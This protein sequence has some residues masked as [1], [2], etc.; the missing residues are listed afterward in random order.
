MTT[1]YVRVRLRVEGVVQGV[2][3]RP[4]VHAIAVRH[5]LTGLVANDLGGVLIEAAGTAESLARFRQALE[6]EAPPL[7]VIERISAQSV[8]PVG[9]GE[10]TGD[11]FLIAAS[12]SGTSVIANVDSHGRSTSADV[13]DASIPP[14]IA[15]CADCLRELFDPTDRRFRHPFINC[16]N[17]GPRFTVVRSLPYDRVRTTMAAFAMCAA[18]E[19][20]YHDPSDRRF[21]AQPLC[22]PAC[23]PTLRLVD[24]ATGRAL[25]GDPVAEA[26]EMLRAGRVLAV[27]GLG[28]YHLAVDS[29][30]EPAVRLLRSRKRREEKPFAVMVPDTSTARRLCE[31]E[32]TGLGLLRSVR[33][34]IVLLPRRAGA[35]LAASVAPGC[36]DLGLMLPYTPLHHLLCAQLARPYVLTSGNLFDEP[37]AYD[38][39]DA[40]RRLAG[41]ADAFLTHDRPI[42]ARA[43]DSVVR[44]VTGGAHLVRR[45]RGHAPEPLALLSPAQRP[46]L[47]CG[48]QLKSTFCLARGRRAVVS[49]HVGDLKHPDALRSF[50]DGVAHHRRLFGIDPE[51]IAHDLHP[52]YLSTKYAH[53]LADTWGAELVGVQHHHAHIAS[54]LV[55]NG[56]RGPVIGVAFDGLGY[57]SDHTLWGGEFL[58]AD[59][60]GFRRAG[61]FTPV[62]LPG[63]EAAVREPWRMAVVY[64]DACGDGRGDGLAVR[65]RNADRWEEV[66]AVA[67][68]G[69]H[70]PPTSSVGRLFDA[71]AAL[72]DLRDAVS[73]EG[74]AA[75]ELERCADPSVTGAYVARV[76]ADGLVHGTDLV[77]EVVADVRAGTPNEVIAARFHNGVAHAVLDGC[78]GLRETTGLELVALSGGVFQ[79]ALLLDRTTDLLRRHGFRVLTHR[80]IPPNDGGISLGQAAVAAA[81]TREGEAVGPC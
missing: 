26:A 68:S 12:R 34:P 6:R 74:Q 46:V 13:A 64:L 35:G 40:L 27:K 47:A 71:V 23:G 10:Q 63:G 22:C 15:T 44:V 25:P 9:P 80:H 21:H 4:F 60:T 69:V 45:A 14:D 8:E 38:E 66:R 36:R 19:S 18:C 28:G 29:V 31:V 33:A 79:N 65:R 11:A 75:V 55:D 57:G 37:I 17:C 81:R 5:G 59:L 39:A 77:R 43:D 42:H 70:A 62:P 51:V 7:S 49:P 76:R 32:D 56:V 41:I 50:T 54:C 73:Y 2:G 3:F 78:C 58:V 1:P 53:D 67:R 48:A 30:N 16:T 20:E 52:E 61:H 72:L 24:A